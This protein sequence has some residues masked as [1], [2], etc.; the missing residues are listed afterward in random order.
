MPPEKLFG[1]F[2]SSNRVV[3][4]PGPERTGR[5][6]VRALAIVSVIALSF[7]A[8]GSVGLRFA[9]GAFT[10][11]PSEM[12]EG[13]G[14]EARRL[15]EAA[16]EDVS[17]KALVD[18]HVHVVG[19]GTNETGTWLHPKML[20]WTDPV[21]RVKA[22]FYLSGA[23]VTDPER[24]DEQYVARLLNLARSS[25]GGRL[26]LLAFDYRYDEDGK[27]DLEHSEFYT[28]NAYVYDLA[29]AAPDVF[30]PAISVH[31]HRRDA[32]A[33][34]HRWADRG[35]RFVKW[36][37]NAMGIDASSARH[38][39]YYRVMAE[40]RMVLL[41]HVGEEQAVEAEED[42]RLGNPLLFRRPLD[43][44]VTVVMAHCASLGTNEDLDHP[45]VEVSNFELFL[46][47]MDEP[48]YRGRLYGEI[49]AM[50][51][52]NRLPG[53]LIELLERSNLH[54]RLVNGSDYPLP[55]INIVI[56]TH[57]LV[58]H[59]LLTA[60]EREALNEI[61][62]YN[63]LVFDYVVKRTIRSPESGIRFPAS[64]FT[65]ADLGPLLFSVSDP[66]SAAS[67]ESDHR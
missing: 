15:L 62:D 10:H 35:I 48:R 46:R 61:Y 58:R 6:R 64:V 49:S 36:L 26:L 7:W 66:G 8:A 55:A 51:Q 12:A 9:G 1:I 32:V 3:K 13:L 44:G 14:S 11:E 17:P 65:G 40:R 43:A 63:P 21:A 53:P 45:G 50:T 57:A 22:L 52:V 56:Q 42:Q 29:R 4:I 16:F 37:P 34:L 60:A 5:R 30:A 25:R 2:G 24:A 18:H 59:G 47:L 28:P 27:P 38:D 33:A 39:D 41:A 20:S 31:P 67:L 23:G 54:P 19:L